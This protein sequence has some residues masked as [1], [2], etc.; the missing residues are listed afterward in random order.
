M[1]NIYSLS[2]ADGRVRYSCGDRYV[3]L[4]PSCPAIFID[5]E[6]FA[7]VE[8]TNP[9]V[10]RGGSVIYGFM[11]RRPDSDGKLR[12]I[13]VT[14]CCELSES[15]G[16]LRKYAVLVPL[17]SGGIITGVTVERFKYDTPP[18]HR[19]FGERKSS[20]PYYFDG[21][22]AALEF[23]YAVT[24]ATDGVLSLGH[25]PMREVEYGVPYRTKNA[26]FGIADGVTS[27][28]LFEHYIT[29]NRP[30]SPEVQ[31][32]YNGWWTMPMRYGE[33]DALALIGEFKEKLYD[34]YGVAFD[35]F[36]IDM[37]WSA[38][39][40]VWEL[41]ASRYPQGLDKAKAA[42]ES[43]GGRL[44]LWISPSNVYSPLSFDNHKAIEQGYEIMVRQGQPIGTAACLAGKKYQSKLKSQLLAYV[45]QYGIMHVKFDGLID[46]CGD[47]SHG[48]PTGGDGVRELIAEGLIDVFKALSEAQPGIWLEATCLGYSASPFWLNYC[49]SVL[50]TYG[51][52][53]PDG[54]LAAPNFRDSATSGRDYYNLQGCDRLSVP[55]KF[56]ELL[57]RRTPVGRGFCKR[58]GGGAAAWQQFCPVLFQSARGHGRRAL[59]EACCAARLVQ[60]A[61]RRDHRDNRPAPEE[62]G[63]AAGR[64]H[65]AEPVA[66]ARAVR[67]SASRERRLYGAAPQS[68]P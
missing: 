39:D 58:H 38:E 40:K 59:G 13:A 4:E 48:H 32:N 57:G 47:A 50:G 62:L 43:T 22:F 31:A 21:F 56:Q 16:M 68:V 45:C 24:A 51:D 28:R 46:L 65:A 37:G 29:A 7:H 61:L 26:L 8:L 42:V 44:G 9:P 1:P 15:D 64:R 33:D 5:G 19:D 60:V 41:D 63:A 11:A 55:V 52:D 49:S 10:V 25:T 14:V 2:Y 12:E 66:A 30:V 36:T 67:L 27:E 20:Y 53:S 18:V 6:E 34:R 54:M 23:P 35:T 3:E 17:F